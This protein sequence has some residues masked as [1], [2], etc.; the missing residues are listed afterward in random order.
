MKVAGRH[1]RR[2]CVLASDFATRR[3][4]ALYRAHGVQAIKRA[5]PQGAFIGQYDLS[6]FETLFLAGERADTNTIQWAE[7]HLNL[8]VI[9]HWWQTERA[10]RFARIR[11]AL[12]DSP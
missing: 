9:D 3:E 12:P 10:G 1:A 6:R 11:L 8:P 5:D 2:R 4:G 7:Q